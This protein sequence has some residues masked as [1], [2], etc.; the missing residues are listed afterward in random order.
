ML[1]FSQTDYSFSEDNRVSLERTYNCTYYHSSYVTVHEYIAED[2]Y[3]VVIWTHPYPFS[4]YDDLFPERYFK[5]TEEGSRFHFFKEMAYPLER[6]TNLYMK[7]EC[8][9]LHMN[10]LSRTYNVLTFRSIH[11]SFLKIL[12]IF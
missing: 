12:T 11:Y 3:C 8:L 1:H 10:M 7:V 6:F 4:E 9:L 5:H 2:L